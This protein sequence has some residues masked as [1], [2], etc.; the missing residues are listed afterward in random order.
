MLR[1]A[2]LSS[3]LLTA[4]ALGAA[5]EHE[6]FS[7]TVSLR[8]AFLYG[9]VE[10]FLQT[11][12]GGEPGSSS[13][14]R[15][16]LN[17][18]NIDNAAF[19]DVLGLVHWRRLAFYAGYEGIGLD[20]DSVLTDTLVSRGATFPA[21]TSVHSQVDLNWLR[22]GVGCKFELAN[23]RLEILP[24]ADLALLDFSYKLSGGGEAVD[25][26]Y[27]KGCFRLGMEGKYRCF[28]PVSL[29]L[30]AEA[31]LPIS[32]TPQIATFIGDVEFE[33]L[34]RSKRFHPV[35]FVGGGWQ[36]IEYE[37]NQT[38]PNHIKVDFGPLVTAGIALGF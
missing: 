23:H 29:R 17:E 3:V 14:R 11:P 30:D 28:G 12:A 2:I 31:S 16:T 38:L 6:Q 35:V 13:S 34:R 37:D 27:S 1:H 25:R 21:G 8:G 33:L 26:S 32:N 5:E 18:L 36:R 15:P 10:G 22:A 24:K 4:L 7:E 19:Y 20:G 9:P